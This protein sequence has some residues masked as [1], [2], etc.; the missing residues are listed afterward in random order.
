MEGLSEE[1]R[2]EKAGTAVIS[3]VCGWRETIDDFVIFI[4]FDLT[5]GAGAGAGQGAG[6][7]KVTNINI[8]IP[9][10]RGCT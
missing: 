6:E 3:A 9:G 8:S 10:A 2:K 4:D 1:Q 5:S 7:Q